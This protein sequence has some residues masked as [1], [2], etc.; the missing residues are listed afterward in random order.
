MW[1]KFL[2]ENLPWQVSG[3]LAVAKPT[4]IVFLEISRDVEASLHVCG[5]LSSIQVVA[6][7]PCAL[8]S[9]RTS[10]KERKQF[11]SCRLNHTRL[12]VTQRVSLPLLHPLGSDSAPQTPRD[13]PFQ[14]KRRKRGMHLRVWIADYCMNNRIRVL[15]ESLKSC[16]RMREAREFL[17]IKYV[18]Y[19]YY[20]YY[21]L[22]FPFR[23][24]K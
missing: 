19:Y 20:Y 24:L 21:Y 22:N 11:A 13:I 6:S 18:N 14:R 12:T 16:K 10:R 3:C 15:S 17:I 7:Y 1:R 23:F 4:L 9:Y 8:L 2:F 5:N